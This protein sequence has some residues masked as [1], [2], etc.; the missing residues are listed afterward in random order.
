MSSDVKNTTACLCTDIDLPDPMKVRHWLSVHWLIFKLSID[1]YCTRQKFDL[2][3]EQTKCSFAALLGA[4]Q[5][6]FP[7]DYDTPIWLNQV[8]HSNKSIKAWISLF[9]LS[10]R[11]SIS[12]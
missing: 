6:D 7:T 4:T 9:C 8:G 11:Q 2:C 5:A 3:S 12:L 10:I 1:D